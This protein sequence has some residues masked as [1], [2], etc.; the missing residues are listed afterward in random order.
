LSWGTALRMMV[1]AEAHKPSITTVSPELRRPCYL[2][3]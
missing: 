2:S 1:Q 3:M